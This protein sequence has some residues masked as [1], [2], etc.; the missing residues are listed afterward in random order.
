MK[1][2][3]NEGVKLGIDCLDICGTMVVLSIQYM[4]GQVTG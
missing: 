4:K 2:K 3:S 1:I